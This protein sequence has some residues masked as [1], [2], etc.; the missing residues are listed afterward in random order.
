MDAL[1]TGDMNEI[2]VQF[3]QSQ[4]EEIIGQC[5]AEIERLIETCCD[6]SVY[7]HRGIFCGNVEIG[8][9]SGLTFSSF[10][11]TE[12][13]VEWIRYPVGVIR[14]YVTGS[15]VFVDETGFKDLCHVF[16]NIPRLS[17]LV[18][19]ASRILITVLTRGRIVEN[20]G[21]CTGKQSLANA[22]AK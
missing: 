21:H 9:A 3:F 18:F 17:S 6:G 22:W 20:V 16:C 12:S 19:L 14:V 1:S 7:I 2:Q 8:P 10:V 13:W 15:C 5:C 11:C 4:P